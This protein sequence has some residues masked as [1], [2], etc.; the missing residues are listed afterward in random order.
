MP[1]S[2]LRDNLVLEV[3][4]YVTGPYAGALLG[5]AGA[6]VIKIE[7]VQHGD[8]NR[9]FGREVNLYSPSF[10]SL[11]RNK[12][13]LTLDIASNEGKEVFLKLAKNADVLIENSRPGRMEHLGLG[14]EALSLVNPR[15]VYCSISGFGQDG[16]YRDRP[17]YDTVAQGL[18]GLLGLLTGMKTPQPVGVSI[19]DHITALYACYGILVALLARERTG[20][21]QWVQTSLLQ[22]SISFLESYSASYLADGTITSRERR[23][24]AI[25]V[26]CFFAEDNLPFVIHLSSPPKFWKG[27]TEAVSRPD[28]QRDARFQDRVVR[29]QH[30]EELCS[31]LD[32]IFKQ[33]PL[34]YWLETLQNHDVPCAPINSVDRAFE[35]MQ[36]Q[37]LK[38]IE[39]VRHPKMGPVKLIRSPVNLSRTPCEVVMPPPLLGEHSQEILSRLGY[40]EAEICTLRE[41]QVV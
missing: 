40:T 33:R 7:D 24:R 6:E 39:E 13:S 2:P 25:P 3:A 11:N 29:E 12:K 1:T 23:I 38:V 41:K 21:G 28:L 32:Q 19:S 34:A 35:D 36:V 22:S 17:G 15:L 4:S 5:D 30:Y 20:A 8:P 27:L 14:Y 9:G 31:I 18:S 26:L 37:H 10:R 16:P